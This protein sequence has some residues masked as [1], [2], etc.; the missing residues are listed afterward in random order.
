MHNKTQSAVIWRK[1]G[2]KY[3]TDGGWSTDLASA[4][5]FANVDDAIDY[6]R[7]RT[8]V[9]GDSVVL[10][11]GTEADQI[12]SIRDRLGTAA[13]TALSE[14][15]LL[16]A[17][18]QT[19]A[20]APVAVLQL[21]V[22]RTKIVEFDQGCR[23]A[24]NQHMGYAFLAGLALN[25]A[26][27]LVPHG[28]K[29]G[30]FMK[31]REENLPGVSPRAATNYMHFAAALAEKHPTVG[32]LATVADFTSGRL[33]LLNGELPEDEKQEVLKAVHDVADGKTLTQMYR[34]LGV[35]RQ[36][37]DPNAGPKKPITKPTPEEIHA[38]RLAGLQHA[39]AL[40][41]GEVSA[42]HAALEEAGTLAHPDQL[43][44]TLHLMDELYIRI[45][46]MLPAK[47]SLARPKKAK[48][49]KG[50]AK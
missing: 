16:S 45:K 44:R 48:A 22:L 43:K 28:N 9:Q 26:K 50:G 11:A 49:R 35:I 19:H 24:F 30:G 33:E 47:K 3:M 46:L 13:E 1:L 21:A 7:G 23:T 34:D 20:L 25:C 37:K 18:A 8:S 6:A 15:G 27:A 36:P 38:Q 39:F 32:K 5:V 42:L 10:G 4:R 41:W 31:W 29:G 12:I 14:M 2:N 17:D 40:F